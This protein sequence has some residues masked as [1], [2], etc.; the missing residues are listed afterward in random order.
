[1]K[2]RILYLLM[3]GLGLLNPGLHAQNQTWVAPVQVDLLPEIRGIGIGLTEPQSTFHV[4][5]GDASV[6]F[7]KEN[8]AMLPDFSN[9]SILGTS[10]SLKSENIGILGLGSGDG[11]RN[12]GISGF[13]SG[14]GGTNFGMTASG[15]G[16][17]KINIGGVGFASGA[18]FNMGFSGSANQPKAVNFGVSG[19]AT[20][21]QGKNIGL[22]G[23]ASGGQFNVSIEGEAFGHGDS[24]LNIGL[25][26][27]ALNLEEGGIH[28]GVIAKAFGNGDPENVHRFPNTGIQVRTSGEF[29]V[30]MGVDV[31][32][33]EDQTHY[34][35]MVFPHHSENTGVRTEIHASQSTNTGMSLSVSGENSQNTGI[36][37]TADQAGIFNGEVDINGNVMVSGNVQ[38]SSFSS[39][40]RSLQIPET[41]WLQAPEDSSKS[42]MG[43][44][45]FQ[46]ILALTPLVYHPDGQ[47]ET[48]TEKEI[49]SFSPEDLSTFFPNLV[50]PAEQ[51]DNTLSFSMNYIGLIPLMV[52][53][54]KEQ[55]K[56]IQE[57]EERISTLTDKM[58]KE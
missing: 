30:N 11:S 18:P 53:T 15:T 44:P 48:P 40:E 6:S 25:V 58:E 16:A 47:R 35:P 19:E 38:A 37:V 49:Y 33:G 36:R 5:S 24:M 12:T 42:V 56:K 3:A 21:L 22:K 45:H 41:L 20:G 34:G 57:L 9:V 14:N 46:K 1:M 32:I 2:F 13:A 28:L 7:F 55:N 50:L 17:G 54:L 52:H 51:E 8:E 39:P 29:T 10:I 43:D 23:Y 4:A 27:K 31:F 26:A